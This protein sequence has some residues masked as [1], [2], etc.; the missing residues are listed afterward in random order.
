TE[1]S[2]KQA[3][4]SQYSV[5]TDKPNPFGTPIVEVP[6]ELPKVSMELFTSFDQCLIDEVT[7]VQNIFKQMELAVEQHCA[8][9]AK[10]QTKMEMFCKKM[11]DS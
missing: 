8:E 11:I 10:F 5:Q 9:K 1:S 3:F 4:W 7:E 6:K 2:A